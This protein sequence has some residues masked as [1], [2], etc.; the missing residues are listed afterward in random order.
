LLLCCDWQLDA[1]TLLWEQRN[2][3]DTV[4]SAFLANTQ[5][6]I[7]SLRKLAHG[8]SVRQML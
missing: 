8:I 3:G 7:N 5:K 4:A 6:D 2:G 1:R